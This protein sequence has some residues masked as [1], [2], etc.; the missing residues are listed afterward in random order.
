MST[1]LGANDVRNMSYYEGI[2]AV[3]GHFTKFE[4][5]KKS[6]R[7]SFQCPMCKASQRYRHQA[8]M[9]VAHFSREGSSC[10]KELCRE[11]SFAGLAVYEP[12]I[13][14]PFRGYLSELPGYVNSAF[15][16]DVSPGQ[17]RDGIRCENLEQ[18]TF[19]DACFDLII[20]SDIMEHV[21]HPGKAF[22]EASRVLRRGGLY[23]LTVPF[24]WPLSNT[25]DARVD[26]SGPED[27]HIKEPRYHGDPLNPDGALV[28]NDFGLDIAHQMQAAGF[29]VLLPRSLLYTLT[30]IARRY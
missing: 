19:P 24:S 9:I 29:D 10:F 11:P 28:Y 8:E 12:G 22:R 23:I 27:V 5:S 26:V 7:E 14:G 15:W 30:V 13:I 3:C 16:P 25:T 4:N 18:L 1:T 21:R 17:M 2:C 20:S 6:V